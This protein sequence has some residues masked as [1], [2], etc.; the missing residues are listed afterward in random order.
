[1][2]NPLTSAIR[3]LGNN[4]SG[5]LTGKN[6]L[7]QPQVTSV[8]GFTVPGTPLISTRDFFLSQMESWFTSIPL[9]S[10]WLVL[11]QGYPTLLQTE[12]LRQLEDQ[13]G[14]YNNF[15]ISQAT[16]I[17]KSFPLNKVIGCV[18]AQGADI[19][20]LQS[21]SISRDKPFQDKQKGFVSGYV[22][23]GKDPYGDLTLQFLETNTSFVDFTIRPWSMLAS[24][25]GF[26]SRE[27]GDLRNVGTT[28]SILQYTRSYQKLSQIPRKI[29]TFYDCMPISVDSK[30]LTMDNNEDVVRSNTTWAFSRYTIQNNLYLPLPDIINKISSGNINRLSPFQRGGFN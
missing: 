3:G 9:K 30:N 7:S 1:M 26:V 21:L 29:W 17:A 28:I 18:Y 4:V 23:N 6:P 10:Q 15:D 20:T 5:L 24:H 19:P 13:V 22:S 16:A 25:F 14:N 12:I 2:N 27:E 8:F 11:I